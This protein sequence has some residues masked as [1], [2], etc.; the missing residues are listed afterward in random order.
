[1]EYA[2][3]QSNKPGLYLLDARVGQMARNAAV[4]YNGLALI[5]VYSIALCRYINRINGMSI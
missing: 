1:M 3:T 4:D 2:W 5:S